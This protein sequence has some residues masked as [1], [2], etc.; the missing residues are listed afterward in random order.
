MIHIVGPVGFEPTT[1]SDD[2]GV[3][4]DACGTNWSERSWA[5]SGADLVASQRAKESKAGTAAVLQDRRL[6]P[7]P[8]GRGARDKAA[9]LI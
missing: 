3:S 7:Q 8:R 2:V 1:K 6:G 5:S 9:V 4:Q